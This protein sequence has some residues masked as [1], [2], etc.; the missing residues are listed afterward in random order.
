MPVAKVS[1]L[2][3]AFQFCVS[4]SLSPLSNLFCK[5]NLFISSTVFYDNDVEI[6]LTA[7][8]TCMVNFMVRLGVSLGLELGLHFSWEFC[9]YN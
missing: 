1:V 7:T 2:S 3:V 6:W 8:V 9:T 5:L 4:F